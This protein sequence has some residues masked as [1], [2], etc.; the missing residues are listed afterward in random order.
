LAENIP[1]KKKKK[2]RVK[3]HECKRKYTGDAQKKIDILK[4]IFIF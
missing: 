3:S 4:L 1:V 2:K